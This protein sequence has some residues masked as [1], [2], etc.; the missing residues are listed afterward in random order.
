MIAAVARAAWKYR[1]YIR[2]AVAA[3]FK[4]RFI[5]S[6]IGATWIVIQPIM[7][8]VLFATVLSSVMVARIDGVDSRYGYIVYLLAGIAC[9][10]LFS[11]VVQRCLTVFVDQA[12]LLRKMHFPRITLP[13]V[14][15]GS[16]MVSNIALVI[17]VVLAL[18]V[19]GIFPTIQWLWLPVLMVATAAMA[20]GL[21]LLL[22]T[23]N[24]F[25]RDI[26]QV[27]G[28]VL[29]FWFWMT[30]IVYPLDIVPDGVRMTLAYNP[31]VPLVQA[32]QRV[33][34]HG[35]APSSEVWM[36]VVVALIL[37]PFAMLVFRRASAE[38]VDAL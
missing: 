12:H 38:L 18:P 24:V 1:G 35:A 17:V 34:L 32:Y 3:E 9:W 16:A 31:L 4:G 19:L 23:L 20:T 15:V 22:G 28:V 21:G 33:L 14:V 7:Q 5:R 36:P 30:P 25:S 29:Q 27:S 26:G 11:E 8:V 10:N 13:L 6:R 37:L 2:S